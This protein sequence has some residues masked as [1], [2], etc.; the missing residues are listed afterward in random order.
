MKD[1]G[2]RMNS[3]EIEVYKK[4]KEALQQMGIKEYLL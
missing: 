3:H 4:Q 2:G 1:G